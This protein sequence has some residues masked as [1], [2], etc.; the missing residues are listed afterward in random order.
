MTTPMLP[1][2]RGGNAV[3]GTTGAECESGLAVPPSPR[4]HAPLGFA[5]LQLHVQSKT[6]TPVQTH[7]Q[8]HP[9]AHM[10]M[11][12]HAHP[13]MHTHPHMQ[14]TLTQPQMTSQL[15][16]QSQLQAANPEQNCL[17]D[18]L[19]KLRLHKYYPVFKQL[20]MEEFLALTEE[21]L[22]KYDLT[23]GAKKKLKTQL[24]L[25]KEKRYVGSQFP[26][27]CSGVARVTP[28]SH[29]SP[30][31]HAHA[32]SN[33]EL[34]VEVEMGAMPLPRDSSSSS[35][36][37]S[38]PNSPMTPQHRDAVLE[39]NKDLHRRSE[40][41]LDPCDK[42]RTVHMSPVMSSS[43][44]RP[45]AQV[46]PV[47]NDPTSPSSNP[48]PPITQGR[49]L[50]MGRKP[51]PPPL[52][53]DDRRPMVGARLET[54]FPALSL[55]GTPS[56]VPCPAGP[57]TPGMLCSPPPPGV[58]VETSSAL[59]AT[60]NTLHH[61]SHPPLHLQLSP[62]SLPP[63]ERGPHY[64]FFAS[65][66]SASSSSSYSSASPSFS[67]A[68][69]S[70]SSLSPSARG[71]GLP[72]ATVSS[73]P[74]VAVPGNTYCG[75]NVSSLV[76][77]SSPVSSEAVCY[78]ASS[79]SFAGQASSSSA[80]SSCLCVCSSCGCSGNC[81]SYAALP[82]SYAGYFP[83]PLSGT[84]VFTL[85]P[86]LHLSP[87]LTGGA[88]PAAAAPAP[89]SYPV[90]APPLYSNSL[91][92]EAQQQQQGLVIPPLQG[93]LGTGGS[94][95]HSHG[96]L[97][98]GGHVKKGSGNISCYNCGVSGHRAQDCKQPPMDCPQQGTFR[99]KYAPHT[100]NQDSGD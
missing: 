48:P 72:M 36:Y 80:S 47:Q 54:L 56:S 100:D 74:M 90:V 8:A 22:N 23:Q 60:S 16:A 89:F 59:T 17:L 26:M 83:H 4:P 11:Y 40:A 99:L 21:D 87:L 94:M 96:M 27:P 41:I 97:G 57:V 52:S 53:A 92:H 28:S 6:P 32:N 85:G 25:Q 50:V 35:G 70:K 1:S 61:V 77:S 15:P 30:L 67:S 3:L 98:N 13:Q 82:T 62:S 64:P 95:Y 55:E 24:E 45:T 88:T 42:E 37:S 2:A 39:R 93:Y 18:W 9:H 68:Y 19:R 33:T 12:A 65:S 20:T 63:R 34:R 46:L 78:G 71:A 7:L 84:S 91:S 66:S 14:Q 69:S 31:A 86:L 76:P 10:Q 73:V 5:Q 51:R 29:L 43:P 81:G 58:M 75:N 44:S 38:A 79:S 49:S